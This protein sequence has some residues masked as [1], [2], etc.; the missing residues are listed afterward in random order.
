LYPQYDY[1]YLAD[2]ANAPY[3]TKDADTIKIQTFKG[4]QWL[5]DYG[6]GIVIVACNTAAACSIRARQTQ[7]PGLK[8]LSVSVPG[9]E[10]MIAGEYIHIGIL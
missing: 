5:F 4:L 8:A 9:V 6:A 3:G 2:T 7:Y 10:K 1:L